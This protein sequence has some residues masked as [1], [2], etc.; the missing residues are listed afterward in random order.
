[1]SPFSFMN[2][3]ILQENLVATAPPPTYFPYE[4]LNVPLP[5]KKDEI[6][7]G[8][9]LQDKNGLKCVN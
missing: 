9:D 7:Y 5:N 3:L 8:L 2:P 4:T 6:L 1:M